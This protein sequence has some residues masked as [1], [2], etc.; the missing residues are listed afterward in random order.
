[1]SVWH[2]IVVV[3]SEST[4]RGFVAGFIAARG[5]EE[6]VLFGA[7]VHVQGAT[8]GDRLRELVGAGSHH[9]LLAPAAVAVPLAAAV[10]GRGAETGLQVERIYEIVAA[11][12]TFDAEA[13]AP[14]VAARIESALRDAVPAGVTVEAFKE[15]ETTD[16][17]SRGAELYA[18]SH[19]YTYRAKGRV[20]GELT[21]VLE[22]R[23]RAE[24]IDFVKAEAIT[25]E[26]REIT[27]PRPS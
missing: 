24:E 11:A 5:Q 3:G 2:E 15:H 26:K 14:D 16:D 20:A 12:F 22:M 21:G 10:S 8:I 19:A 9:T 1:M 25:L 23:R 18:P 27:P 13:F 4:V 7:D 6:A 17:R